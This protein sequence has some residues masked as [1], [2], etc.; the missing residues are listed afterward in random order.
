MKTWQVGADG[1]A[2][3]WSVP[4]ERV[5]YDLSSIQEGSTDPSG[6]FLTP[7]P[8]FA[9]HSLLGS[10]EWYVPWNFRWSVPRGLLTG[11]KS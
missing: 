6:S 5:P 2:C 10:G 3:R 1:L 9:A 8:D 7:T 4:E 11:I